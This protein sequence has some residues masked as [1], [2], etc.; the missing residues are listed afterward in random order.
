MLDD[1]ANE[2]RDGMFAFTTPV[3]TSV[4]GLCVATIKWIPAALAICVILIIESST[5]FAA[6]NIKSANSSIMTTI[7]GILGY[8]GL[9]S[10]NSLYPLIFLFFVCSKIS[11]LLSISTT[12]FF[13]AIDAF[14]GSV[15]TGHSKWGT[16]LY[17]LSST[18]LG[19]TITSFTCSG[20]VLIKIDVI[21]QFIQ[22]DL[23]DPVAPAT[24]KC[25]VVFISIHFTLPMISF[26][27]PTA[28][29]FFSFTSGIFD[30]TS[31]KE[32]ELLTWFGNSIPIVFFPGIGASILTSRAANA[33]AISL[34]IDNNLLTFVP[35][36]ISN[37]YCVTVGPILTWTI[38]PVISK[39][40]NTFS[41]SVIFCF[42]FVS[43]SLL[44]TFLT[45]FNKLIGGNL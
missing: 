40:F 29:R 35:A 37:S 16:P 28:N 27:N 36:L 1:T 11:Y 10:Q 9:L 19:S 42:A 18:F 21:M 4:E 8:S 33:K 13:K 6:T 26:P 41:N 38:F 3:I 32:T 5:S 7:Y 2:I 14:L 31:L 17:I 39:S 34:W 23:P 43:F 44:L 25:G 15:T 30:S 45:V 22:T 20:L 24:N 12:I